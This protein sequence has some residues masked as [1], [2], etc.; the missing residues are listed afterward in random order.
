VSGY[1]IH[2]SPAS[3]R[4]NEFDPSGD[5]S[6]ISDTSSYNVNDELSAASTTNGLLN[7]ST[8]ALVK[9]I[10]WVFVNVFI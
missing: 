1:A 3:S 5:P 4:E 10:I 2:V 7:R 8:K 6:A 9:A